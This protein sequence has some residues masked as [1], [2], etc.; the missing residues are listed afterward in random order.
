[1]RIAAQKASIIYRHFEDT[2]IQ[3]KMH[4]LLELQNSLLFALAETQYISSNCSHNALLEGRMGAAASSTTLLFTFCYA[5]VK[6]LKKEFEMKMDMKKV[7]LTAW[8][9]S[10]A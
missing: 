6:K 10:H 9:I 3:R 8:I 1:M 2:L 4:T 7:E 5:Y